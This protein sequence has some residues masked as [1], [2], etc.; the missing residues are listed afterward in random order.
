[1][2]EQERG[3]TGEEEEAVYVVT[4][5]EGVERELVPVYTFDCGD[6][7]YVVLID[8][9]DSEADGLILRIEQDGEEMVLANIEDDEEWEA[10]VEIYNSILEE[11]QT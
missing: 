3:T 7:E 2:T 8:R 10:V 9:N 4:D 6:N 5:E 11:E 1:M